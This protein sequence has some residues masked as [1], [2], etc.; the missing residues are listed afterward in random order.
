MNTSGSQEII[1]TRDQLRD[2]LTVSS[3]SDDGLFR[4]RVQPE[5]KTGPN[6]QQITFVTLIAGKLLEIAAIVE[7][8]SSL[9][10]GEAW[11]AHRLDRPLRQFRN[12]ALTEYARRA[13]AAHD[14]ARV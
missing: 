10:N 8:V 5:Y 12:A 6:G 3:V 4:I 1:L 7:D 9:Q 14:P 2:I 11:Q 13:P